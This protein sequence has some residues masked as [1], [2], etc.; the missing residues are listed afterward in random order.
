LSACFE[1]S[2]KE[3]VGDSAKAHSSRPLGYDHS[4]VVGREKAQE[5]EFHYSIERIF[6]STQ[7]GLYLLAV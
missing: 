6:T 7:R 1:V 3:L 4:H 2:E 5:G